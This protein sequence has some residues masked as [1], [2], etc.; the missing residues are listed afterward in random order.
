MPKQSDIEAMLRQRSAELEAEQKAGEDSRFDCVKMTVKTCGDARIV[1]NNIVNDHL[2]TND[3]FVKAATAG[4]TMQVEVR[5]LA[6]METKMPIIWP[7]PT[8]F[9]VA[10]TAF[11][12]IVGGMAIW[13]VCAMFAVLFTS[14]VAEVGNK[15]AMAYAVAGT[16]GFV[17]A[18]WLLYAITPYVSYYLKIPA[19]IDQLYDDKAGK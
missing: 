18:F 19:K 16:M 5:Y 6:S 13:L 4:H 17:A 3:D 15:M 10:A 12:F 7:K 8:P 9:R 2:L 11:L 14:M 1:A